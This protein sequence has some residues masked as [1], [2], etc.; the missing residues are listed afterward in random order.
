MKMRL[1]QWPKQMQFLAFMGIWIGCWLIAILLQGLIVSEITDGNSAQ[2]Y[3]EGM[4]LFPVA[5]MLTNAISQ[6]FIFLLPAVIFAGLMSS[7]ISKY[8]GFNKLQNSKQL[9]W[10][11]M[12]GI[13]AIFFMTSLGSMIRSLDL[14]QVA[15][16]MQVARDAAMKTY[17]QSSNLGQLILNVF[18]L[19]LIPA[20][21]EELFFRGVVLKFMLGFLHK[22]WIAFASTSLF[23]TFLHSSVYEFVPIFLA[24]MLLCW[25]YYKTNNIYNVIVLHFLNNGLQIVMLYL[26]GDAAS[27]TEQA[28]LLVYFCIFALSLAVGFL[29]MKMLNKVATAMQIVEK[30]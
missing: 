11:V 6:V 18:L 2:F 8:L 29:V 15:N 23:F 19:A 30:Q 14:G 16:D 27:G 17:L 20:V 22:P 3:N 13:L 9:L 7:K 25:V 10:S 5:F 26:A 28:D 1:D 21:C 24:S 12:L 4:Q